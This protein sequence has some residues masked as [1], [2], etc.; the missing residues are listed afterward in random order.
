MVLAV[1]AESGPEKDRIINLE[2]DA[3]YSFAGSVAFIVGLVGVL[4]AGYFTVNNYIANVYLAKAT[5][6]A[7]RNQAIKYY[8]A[9]AN[10][11]SSDARVY[12]LLSQT[13]LAQL[14][15]DLKTGPKKDETRENYNARIQNQIASAVNISIRATNADP[16]D[17]Q[18]WANRG[19]IY[20]NLIT[21]VSGA[22]QA[23][24]NSYGES[25]A[26]NSNDPTTYLRLG[27][28]YMT[29]AENLQR[30]SAARS[31]VE[32][33]F[34][35]AEESFKKAVGL[36][37]NYGQ[38]LYNLAVVYE[39][40]N[41]LSDAI[42]QFEKLRAANPRDSSTAFQI[43]LL[44]YRNNQKDNAFYAWQQAVLL[45]PNYSNARW[46]LSLIYEE[47]GDLKRALEQVR[48]IEKFNPE[49]ELVRQRLAQLETGQRTIPPERLLDK[50]PLNQ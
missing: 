24:I 14:A 4:V 49:N 25:L 28:L 30:A 8:V 32:E 18:N 27:N 20:Q 47:R 43:G 13:V 50:K 10:T 44:Y 40:Q 39:R 15:D 19:L 3:K 1:L 45:F 2:S 42:K 34:S 36:Y 7:D 23:A 21:L 6:S 29:L 16:A 26:R 35:K 22:E 31:Q 9:S 12:T 5:R 17:S 41:K 11:N 33:N 48:E 46:Y 37:N 38:A